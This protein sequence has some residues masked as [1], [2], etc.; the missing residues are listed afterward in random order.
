MKTPLQLLSKLPTF[1]LGLIMTLGAIAA[2]VGPV[3]GMKT[4]F[5]GWALL[6]F[7]LGIAVFVVS[8]M[9]ILNKI[10]KSSY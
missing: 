7:L 2:F 10:S 6:V 1:F 5:T 3:L 4:E 8:A 9:A